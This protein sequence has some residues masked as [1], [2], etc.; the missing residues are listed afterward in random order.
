M[1]PDIVFFLVV[2]DL[3]LKGFSAVKQARL[4]GADRSARHIGDLLERH[5]VPV[6]R[7]HRRTLQLGQLIYERPDYLTR[8]SKVEIFFGNVR[9]ILFCHLVKQEEIIVGRGR[10]LIAVVPVIMRGFIKQNTL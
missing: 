4:D 6:E 3:F 5:L 9:T 1:Q 7:Q 10:E 2:F 8:L